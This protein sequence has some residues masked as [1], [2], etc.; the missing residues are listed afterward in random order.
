M[1]ARSLQPTDVAEAGA[2]VRNLIH[3]MHRNRIRRLRAAGFDEKTAQHLSELH[4]PN[5]M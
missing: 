1:S 2:A 4:T 5:L 3:R